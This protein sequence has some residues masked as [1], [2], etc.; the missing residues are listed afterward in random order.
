MKNKAYPLYPVPKIETIREL[1]SASA[2]KHPDAPA[3]GYQQGEQVT[4]KTFREFAADVNALGTYFFEEGLSNGAK[5]AVMGENSYIWIVT[6]MAAACG[7]NIIVPLDKELNEEEIRNTI[8]SSEAVA[9]VYADA[10]AD[11]FGKISEKKSTLK[12]FLNMRYDIPG[13]I[14]KGKDL[15]AKGYMDYVNHKIDPDETCVIIYTSGTTGLAK[16]VML[17]NRSLMSTVVQC[18]QL[19][20]INGP[21]VLLLPLHH[22]YSMAG[23]VFSPML[24]G[25]MC[26]IN[27]ALKN[28]LRDI[29]TAKPQFL[30][31]VPLYVESFC[32]RIWDNVRKQDKEKILRKLIS[33]S[34]KSLKIGIDL[35]RTLF[36]SVL[37][38]FGGNL[39]L[40]VSGGAPLEKQYYQEFRNF[41][42]HII[43]GY[44]I[45]ECSPIVSVNRNHH[46]KE[47]SVGLACTNCKVQIFDVDPQTGFGEICVSGDIVMNGYYNDPAATDEAIRDG[48]F[49]TGDIGYIDDDGF[50]YITGRKKN[51]I[52]RANGKNVHP[53]ELEEKIKLIPEVGEV[54]VTGDKKSIVASIYIDPD[55]E[56]S[57]ATEKSIQKQIKEINKDLPM[58]KRINNIEF[59]DDEFVKTTT[60]KIKRGKEVNA[61]PNHN[62]AWHE[63]ELEEDAE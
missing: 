60:K 46:W 35:R 43:E 61:N 44:G 58:W 15:I 63:V 29:Q 18:N 48:W 3:F 7:G 31:V 24:H 22:T 34:N 27:D 21:T 45:T 12:T 4:M 1:I 36:K 38:A 28:V 16:G 2:G 54:L 10:Y 9:V 62:A 14:S 17:S 32:K 26:F 30:C 50:I 8:A 5:I 11:L 47:G 53:E 40:L 19:A 23:S 41:G 56:K 52:I 39:E 37:N 42:V 55:I 59:R 49:H 25:Q 51:L 20:L 57:R 33:V 13:A 6:Y